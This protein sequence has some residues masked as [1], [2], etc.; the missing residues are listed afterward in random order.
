MELR[1][2]QKE[3]VAAYAGFRGSGALLVLPTGTGKTV[4]MAEIIRCYH[5]DDD[6]LWIAH[7]KEL[8]SQAGK[9]I[10]SNVRLLSKDK[11]RHMDEDLSYCDVLV[12]DEAHHA[13]ANTYTDIVERVC[14]RI[15]LGMT[16]TPMRGDRVALDSV[17]DGVFY[18]K[19]IVDCIRE[20]W[21]ARPRVRQIQTGLD[22]DEVRVS[23]GDY[24]PGQLSAILN[25]H[26]TNHLVAGV[27]A[28]CPKP[29]MVFAVDVGH[30]EALADLIPNSVCITGETQDREELVGA[31]GFDTIV[32]VAVYTE[33]VDIPGLMSIVLARPT[34]SPGLYMQMVGRGLRPKYIPPLAGECL[35]VDFVGNT[36]RYGICTCTLIAGLDQPRKYDLESDDSEIILVEGDLFEDVV[37]QVKKAFNTPEAIIKS[38]RMLKDWSKLVKVD[39]MGIWFLRTPEGHLWQPVCD[40]FIQNMRL[41]EPRDRMQAEIVACH[42]TLCKDFAKDQHLWDTRIVSRWGREE[43]T[44][45]QMSKI[46]AKYKLANPKL[47]LTKGQA[48]RVL[49]AVFGRKK[50]EQYEEQHDR[51]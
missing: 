30:A 23:M 22:F 33:G 17:F 35:L 29:C 13:V 8:L 51:Y 37:P 38:D 14:P 5:S 48:S 44:E 36:Q 31:G 18:E 19:P 1:P 24:Q 4:T 20:G 49:T 6:V 2:Y 40:H 32:N 21:L 45:K 7:R 42:N 15:V 26:S 27:V 9:V 3:A 28:E 46:P 25:N 41:T 10:P 50:L 43:A 12:I 47:R 34:M 39:L 16:A 11:I